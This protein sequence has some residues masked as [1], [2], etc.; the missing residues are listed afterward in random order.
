[1]SKLNLVKSE[2]H[3]PIII[4]N[5]RYNIILIVWV[6]NPQTAFTSSS[7]TREEIF[8]KK[9]KNTIKTNYFS[10]LLGSSSRS[11]T[12]SIAFQKWIE[13]LD[14]KQFCEEI[15]VSINCL[16]LRRQ[17]TTDWLSCK[18]WEEVRGVY[19]NALRCNCKRPIFSNNTDKIK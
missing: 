6:K 1:M 15:N 2:H 4:Q 14:F 8:Q 16:T 5:R 18:I 17:W 13:C 7:T 11:S 10:T 19:I 3:L 12:S 9:K